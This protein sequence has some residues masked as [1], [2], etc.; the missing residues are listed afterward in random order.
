MI[1][2][3]IA[4]FVRGM[5]S[6][7]NLVVLHGPGKREIYLYRENVVA[8]SSALGKKNEHVAEDI[9]CVITTSDGKFISVIETCAEVKA[10]LEK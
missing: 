2:A 10:L 6:A 1:W 3:V 7:F 5:L 8:M 4:A 9:Q